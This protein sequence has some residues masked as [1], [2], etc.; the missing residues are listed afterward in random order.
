MRQPSFFRLHL[1]LAGAL[2]AGLLLAAWLPGLAGAAPL[3]DARK[4]LAD[5]DF[6]KVDEVLNKELAS[7]TPAVDVLRVS[8]E[9]AEKGGRY[10]TANKRITS[11]LRAT[12][13][14]DME[15]V[16]RAAQIADRI[17]HTRLAL[18]RYLLFAQKQTQASPKLEEAFTYLFIN[19]TFPEE[20]KKFVDLY[21]A[22][23]G[24]WRFGTKALNNLLEDADATGALGVAAAMVKAFGNNGGAMDYVHGVLRSA[25]DNYVLG[26][27]VEDR[28]ARAV[29]VLAASAPNELGHIN[30]MFNQAAAAIPGPE[31]LQLILAL[32]GACKRPLPYDLLRHVGAAKEIF[33]L[34][35]RLKA[36]RDVLAMEP[37]YKDSPDPGD[38][39]TFV[40]V[41]VDTPEVFN[42]FGQVLAPTDQMQARLN[43]LKEKYDGSAGTLDGYIQGVRARITEDDKQTALLAANIAVLTPDRFSEL[44]TRTAGAT[45]DPQLGQWTPNKPRSAV[46]G[47]NANLLPIY[48]QLKRK[49]ALVAAAREYMTAYPGTFN[50]QH[51]N[52]HVAGSELL[53]IPEKVALLDE[54]VTKA[55]ATGTVGEILKARAK[56]WGEDAAFKALDG[57]FKTNP[58]GADLVMRTQ[59][60][61]VRTNKFDEVAGIVEAFL[62]EFKGELP[63][64]WEQTASA[65]DVTLM[66]MVDRFAGMSWNNADQIQRCGAVWLERMKFGSS[67]QSLAQRIREHGRQASLAAQA[68][69]FIAL[70]KAAGKRSPLFDRIAYEFSQTSQPKDNLVPLFTEIYPLFG[71]R[72]RP[73]SCTT[74]VV[75]GTAPTGRRG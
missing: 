32:Q 61:M 72:T 68:P 54:I 53:T 69:R 19:G 74:T 30:H 25:A 21:G 73:A 35:A 2:S 75:T 59:A 48:N 10:I 49:D 20:Y 46:I 13:N 50:W 14:Q 64:G 34:E 11:L 1:V 45:I 38:Y 40:R 18:S 27:S 9:A 55:G 3:D 57:K 24:A 12:D 51:V 62:K 8:L 5:G 28:Y 23:P 29:R 43:V 63:G 31:R 39:G 67:Y 44:V 15:M 37:F 6:L 70:A 4:L 66:D 71:R 52:A 7:Q 36:G 16:F 65:Q 26:Q 42:I 41:I 22:G 58:Q 60:A 17:G 47:A 56:D 33:D